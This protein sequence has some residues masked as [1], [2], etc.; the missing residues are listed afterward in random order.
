MSERAEPPSL[1]I[2]TPRRR[3]EILK[4]VQNGFL[5]PKRGLPNVF[6]NEQPAQAVRF[7]FHESSMG[8]LANGSI[9]NLAQ[10]EGQSFGLGFPRSK[11]SLSRARMEDIRHKRENHIAELCDQQKHL[12]L[13]GTGDE[14][15]VLCED[16]CFTGGPE[17]RLGTPR[18][19]FETV[20]NKETNLV[21]AEVFETINSNEETLR[22]KE[23]LLKSINVCC[24]ICQCYMFRQGEEPQE[25]CCGS[26]KRAKG[27]ANG[28]SWFIST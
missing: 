20:E 15:L 10:L 3:T 11:P 13:R 8:Q 25:G 4:R 2:P 12:R 22:Q 18:I 7:P 23:K 9:A 5:T 17:S 24:E 6:G 1:A 28:K 21:T 14:T 26:E 19:D 27:S 16:Y